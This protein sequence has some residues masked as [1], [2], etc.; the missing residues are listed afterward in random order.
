[1]TGVQ[2]CALPIYAY[3]SEVVPIPI[4]L[5]DHID[6]FIPEACRQGIPFTG[7]LVYVD[8]FIFERNIKRVCIGG[9]SIGLGF[10]IDE[11]LAVLPVDLVDVFELQLAIGILAIDV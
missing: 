8:I 3:R 9:D 2:T 6:G 10:V 7:Q 1:M 4:F 5:I 11:G